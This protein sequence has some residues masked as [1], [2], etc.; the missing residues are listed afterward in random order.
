VRRV[1]H[2][3]RNRVNRRGGKL[4]PWMSMIMREISMTIGMVMMTI[5]GVVIVSEGFSVLAHI[6]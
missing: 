4:P 2:R 5:L 3:V 1:S 6:E